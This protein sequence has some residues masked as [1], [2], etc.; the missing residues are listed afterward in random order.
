[1]QSRMT[2][3]HRKSELVENDKCVCVLLHVENIGLVHLFVLV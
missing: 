2:Y 1:M 3:D